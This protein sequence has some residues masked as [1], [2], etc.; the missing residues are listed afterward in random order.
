MSH[1]GT[2]SGVYASVGRPFVRPSVCPSV[3]SVR[4][5]V[6]VARLAEDIDRL[7]HVTW[8][9]SAECG[10]R[11]RAVPRSRRTYTV[12]AERG[13]ARRMFLHGSVQSVLRILLSNL[14][15]NW[16]VTK[17]DCLIF[18]NQQLRKLRYLL[19][20]W[21]LGTEWI[22]CWTQAQKGPGSNRGRDVVE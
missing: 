21:W 10:G 1:A 9:N 14:F 17:A 16:R 20:T 13:L 18:V 2:R 5:F 22:A 4:P 8:H 19:S 12:L 7:L 6:V 11:M 15:D 3:R